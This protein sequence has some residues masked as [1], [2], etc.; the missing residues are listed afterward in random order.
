MMNE[1]INIHKKMHKKTITIIGPTA[2]GK[3]DTAV[4]LA[5]KYN[6]EIISTDSRQIYRY[7][8]IG[9]GKEPGKMIVQKDRTTVTRKTYMS[10]DIPHYM[11]D[12]IHPNTPYNVAKFIKRSDRIRSD[13]LAQ[14]KLPIVCGGTMF[15]AQSLIEQNDFPHVLPNKKLRALLAQKTTKDLFAQITHMDPFYAKKID[16]NNPVRL[17]RAIEIATVIG[18][19]PQ[20]TKKPIDAREH[21]ILAIMHSKDVLHDRIEKRMDTWFDRGIFDEIHTAHH[22][23]NVPWNRLESFGLEYK[24]CTRYVRGQITYSTMRENTIKDL[25]HY[26]KRQITWIRRWEKQNAPI[27][28]ITTHKEADILTQKFLAQK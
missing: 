3:S 13:I 1:R 22:I 19:V 9:T 12:I 27:Y 21:L 17:I 18:S 4:F 10:S 23:H 25:K 8:N 28:R 7:L 6:S 20:I 14:N 2:S 16:N 5:K 11:I 15:W 24:W 26:A